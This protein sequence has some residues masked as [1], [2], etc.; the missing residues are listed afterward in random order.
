MATIIDAI[1]RVRDQASAALQSV[2]RTVGLTNNQ[3]NRF[4]RNLDKFSPTFDKMGLAAV[5]MVGGIVA[6]GTVA[7]D[8]EQKMANVKAISGANEEQFKQLE[9][10]ARDLGASTRFSASQVA[11]AESYLAMAGWKTAEI[12]GAL[13][14]L[15]NLA[16][17]SGEDLATVSDILSDD[18]TA[19]GISAENAGHVADVF[20]AATSNANTNVAM[21]GETFKYAGPVA[22]ALGYSL[23]DVSVAA[24]LMANAGIKASNSGTAL[25]A[26]MLRLVDPPKEAATALQQLGLSVTDSEGKMKPFSTMMTD[27]REK[28][29][30]LD[31]ATKAAMAST[32][33]GT[34]ASAGWLAVVNASQKDFDKLTNSI[35]TC[36]DGEGQ[37]AKMANTMNSTTLGAVDGMK[38]AFE[39]LQITI[40]K[41]T[42]GIPDVIKSLTGI[43]QYVDKLI[44]TNPQIVT[45]ALSFAALL[46]S[47]AVLGEG[48]IFIAD[49]IKSVND[50]REAFNQVLPVVTRT[51]ANVR[52]AIATQ[53]STA[54]APVI[55]AYDSAVATIGAKIAALGTYIQGTT[56]YTTIASAATRIHVAAL[57]LYTGVCTRVTTGFALLR[58]Q[59]MGYSVVARIV[60]GAQM[61]L[62]GAM[63]AFPAIAI[64][65]AVGLVIAILV[66]LA[67]NMD[68]VK[69]VCQVVVNNITAYWEQALTRI[70]PALEQIKT[71][72]N[73]AWQTIS[74]L[75]GI[76]SSGDAFM[77]MWNTMGAIVQF[78][79]Y[80]I[81]DVVTGMV[82]AL[83]GIIDGAVQIFQGLVTFISS[84]MVGDI[85]GAMNGITGIIQG[86]VDGWIGIF[87]GFASTVSSIISN[88]V[89]DNA[90]SK[91]IDSTVSSAQSL[92]TP[93]N[94]AIG[95]SYFPGGQTWVNEQGPELMTL[96]N[97][98]EIIPHS[99]SLAEAFNAGRTTNETNNNSSLAVNIPKLADSIVVREDADIDRI[100]NEMVFKI[101]QF[102]MNQMS[103]AAV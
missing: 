90:I 23:E 102:A 83:A 43:I 17:A 63:A 16:A 29:G 33:F 80:T 72:I 5:G 4:T 85:S 31:E 7:A 68:G 38:S 15:L 97:G 24:G 35:K 73:N 89:G 94:N 45:Y 44:Q 54:F 61:V 18:M 75:L 41:S 14:G 21:L 86:I 64:I 66:S 11:D 70:S 81:I 96:P 46:G 53:L 98:T 51:C 12:T 50:L 52:T 48:T 59:L 36:S 91:F 39:S 62:N 28:M 13:P 40:G 87:S 92:T 58:G 93:D 103:G 56:V 100:A 65:A 74:N 19:F 32:I 71:A 78:V 6:C 88:I 9:G 34:E 30:G 77:D 25:R 2:Q 82:T 26:G 95:T 42:S 57:S 84:V 76:T 10:A 99:E 67:T 27:I 47:I 22:G 101:K 1:V 20:A 8:F 37:A 60:T 79:V 3:F 69:N 55:A 49:T